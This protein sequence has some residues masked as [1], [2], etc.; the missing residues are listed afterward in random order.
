MLT[1]QDRDRTFTAPI[2]HSLAAFALGLMGLVI[3]AV[4]LYRGGS[5]LAAFVVWSVLMFGF[6]VH[7]IRSRVH[8]FADRLVVQDLFRNDT[9]AR[10]DVIAARRDD[11]ALVSVDIAGSGWVRLPYMGTEANALLV[12]LKYWIGQGGG[13]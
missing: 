2:W 5:G 11:L 8:L 12:N 4:D 7:Q 10:A 13:T 1:M 6:G 9:Y 3:A